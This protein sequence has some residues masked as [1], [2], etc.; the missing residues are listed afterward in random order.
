MAVT[1]K[2]RPILFSAPM[3]RAILAGRKT[4]FR[5]VVKPLPPDWVKQFGFT[6][7]TPPGHISGR[8]NFGD[9]GP[10]EKFF[11][12]PYEVGMRLWV[13]ESFFACKGLEHYGR[14]VPIAEA[15]YVCFRDGSQ[16]YRFGTYCHNEPQEEPLNWPS[17]T[18]WRPSTHMPRWASRITLE[19][20][21]VKAERVQDITEADAQAEGVRPFF[22]VTDDRYRPAFRVL[23]GQIN[24]KRPGCSWEAN[25][26][27]WSIA[28][29]RVEA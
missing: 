26:W 25:P 15:S 11:P 28:F 9:E 6:A 21:D 2:S 20:T 5:E 22:P 17:C 13:R 1:T 29:R 7:F 19:I 27:I 10:A 8:G 24:G 3:V 16:K 23:W 14:T 12:C 4:M 18:V